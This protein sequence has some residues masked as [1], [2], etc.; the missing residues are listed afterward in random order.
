M[1]PYQH[2]QTEIPTHEFENVNNSRIALFNYLF[3]FK[4]NTRENTRRVHPTRPRL[5]LSK[6]NFFD[7]NSRFP[8]ASPAPSGAA[9]GPYNLPLCPSPPLPFVV[10]SSLP[11][12][13]E[14]GS[15]LRSE[16]AG[17]PDASLPSSFQPLHL[18]P[19]GSSINSLRTASPLFE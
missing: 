9:R 1:H 6:P 8:L 14:V 19:V 16:T 15:T 17:T 3:F 7:P 2:L 11:F 5:S 13:L 18:A 12:A 10:L 4:K